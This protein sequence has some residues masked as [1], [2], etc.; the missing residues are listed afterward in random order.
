MGWSVAPAG[1]VTAREVVKAAVTTDFNPPIYTV[2]LAAIG[3]KL[4]PFITTVVPTGPLSGEN[5]VI[6]GTCAVAFREKAR[7]RKAAEKESRKVFIS[8]RFFNKQDG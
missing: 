1:A 2:L 8:N 7:V 4:V 5:V 3:L 6:V